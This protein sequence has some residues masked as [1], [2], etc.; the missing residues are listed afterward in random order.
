MGTMRSAVGVGVAALAL[1]A[2]TLAPT[3]TLVDSGELILA[4]SS[5]GVAHPPGFPLYLLLANLATRVPVGEVAARVNFAS[6]L[7][8]ATAAAVVGLAAARCV[9][10]RRAPRA[11]AGRKKRDAAAAPALTGPDPAAAALAVVTAGGLLAFCRAFWGFATIAE[12]YTLNTLLIALVV[13][14]LLQWRNEALDGRRRDGLL[15]VAAGLF[16]LALG[17]HHVTILAWAPGLALLVFSIVRERRISPRDGL[18]IAAAALGGLAVYAYLPIAAARE[19]LLNWGDPDS[20][21]RFYRHVSGWIYQTNLSFEGGRLRSQALQFLRLLVRQYGFVFFPAGLG[22]VAL[23]AVR[24]RRHD[25]TLFW[26]LAL[27]AATATAYGLAYD[28]AEDSEAYFL[29]VFVVCALAAGVGA[30]EALDMARRRGRAALVPLARAA[31]LL[32]VLVAVAGNYPYANRKE[33][34]VARDY[35]RNLFASVEPRGML[36]TEDW[37]VYSPLLY[38][39]E[40]AGER[41]DLAAIDVNLL[42]RSWYVEA[43]QRRLPELVAAAEPAVTTYLH[44]LRGWEADRD[45][46]ARDPRLSARI[47]GRY[48]AMI[49]ALVRAHLESAPVYVTQELVVARTGLA[50]AISSAWQPV[51]QGLVF[52]LYGD[53]GFHDPLPLALDTRSLTAGSRRTESDD[54]VELKVRPAYTGMLVNRGLYLALHGNPDGAREAARAALALSPGDSG[55]RRLAA[56][57]AAA[58]I[59]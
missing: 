12:V 13:C 40:V 50:K 18:W 52:R 39:R 11:A 23:G 1:F 54:V 27:V 7:F 37:Q 31:V 58:Q 57:L 45:A 3:V 32:V 41:R 16:G 15:A 36:L 5:L 49:L 59:P 9:A 21:Q 22:L 55:A 47:D 28:I 29:P 33:E 53:Y 56:Q 20:P 10:I 17:V 44:D 24:L 2:A 48:Q 34:L 6:A 46:Y 19:P 38:M 42:R 43:L 8:G 30:V 26:T 51:P 25:R 35:I 4:A 14:V